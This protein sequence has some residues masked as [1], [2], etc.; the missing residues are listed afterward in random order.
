MTDFEAEMSRLCALDMAVR[1]YLSHL[2]AFEQ[3]SEHDETP[4][5]YWREELDMLTSDEPAFETL[6][7]GRD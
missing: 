5:N 1:N 2:Y 6:G 3:G 4:M 7:V